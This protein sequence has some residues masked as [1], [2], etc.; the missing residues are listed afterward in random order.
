MLNAN[1][2]CC[3][4]EANWTCFTLKYGPL[5][6]FSL[7]ID[8]LVNAL[9][10]GDNM[11]TICQVFYFYRP[12]TWNTCESMDRVG[13]HQHRNRT[14]KGCELITGLREV[15]FTEKRRGPHADPWGI[16]VNRKWGFK[17]SS[18]HTTL[19]NFPVKKDS[20]QQIT[21]SKVP[22]SERVDMGI[23]RRTEHETMTNNNEQNQ[24]VPALNV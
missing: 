24:Q 2:S 22:G 10:G 6:G 20:N 18:Y 17:T 14:R 4:M 15:V 21:V 3:L 13:Y 16:P 7:S 11:T 8:I 5:S 23:W 1:V 12:E 9:S 19:N